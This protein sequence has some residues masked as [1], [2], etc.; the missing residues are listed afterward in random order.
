[1]ETYLNEKAENQT[2]R[3]TKK[4]QLNQVGV[5]SNHQGGKNLASMQWTSFTSMYCQLFFLS[6]TWR[7]YLIDGK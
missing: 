2:Q 6:K 3:R 7:Y 4:I 1:M 5:P